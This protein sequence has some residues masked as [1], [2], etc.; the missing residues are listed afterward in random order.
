MKALQGIE[1]QLE[2]AQRDAPACAPGQIRIRVAAAGLNRA[3]LL[4]RAGHYPPPPGVTDILGLECAGVIS[5]V[6]CWQRLEGRR[7][8]LCIARRRRHG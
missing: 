4:Q 2:W 7:P 1:G 3:D 6:G 5:E 8:G